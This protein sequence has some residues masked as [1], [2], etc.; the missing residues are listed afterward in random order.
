MIINE[1]LFNEISKDCNNW[2]KSSNGFFHSF[3]QTPNHDEGLNAYFITNTIDFEP[4]FFI[5]T[6]GWFIKKLV[7][8]MKIIL[9]NLLSPL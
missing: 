6:I 7:K 8:F 9:I 5:T 1:V 4:P 3:F 2:N